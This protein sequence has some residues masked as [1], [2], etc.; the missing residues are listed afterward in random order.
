MHELVCSCDPKML[1]WSPS[2][3]KRLQ[4]THCTSLSGRLCLQALI[5]LPM[6]SPN[7]YPAHFPSLLPLPYWGAI[8]ELIQI[9]YHFLKIEEKNE[10]PKTYYSVTP[11][12]VEMSFLCFWI[13]YALPNAEISGKGAPQTAVGMPIILCLVSHK[14]H[15]RTQIYIIFY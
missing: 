3:G 10:L 14:T 5:I 6:N 15:A 7:H 8:I 9:N 11:N 4:F 2:W 1:H 12:Q 13:I